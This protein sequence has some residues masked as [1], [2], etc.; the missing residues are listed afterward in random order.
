M[1]TITGQSAEVRWGYYTAATLGPWSVVNG[2]L[3]ATVVNADAYRVSQHPLVFVVIRTKGVWTWPMTSV[4]IA[5]QTLSACLQ[6][7]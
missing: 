7:E 5:G 3:T 4:Q 6:Q 1:V 2:T